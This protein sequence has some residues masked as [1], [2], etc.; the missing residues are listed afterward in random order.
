[1]TTATA[2]LRGRTV[3]LI[4]L[5]SISTLVTAAFIAV[6]AFY[7]A[8][9]WLD[10]SQAWLHPEQFATSAYVWNFPS[11]EGFGERIRKA[12]DWKAFDPNVNRVRPLND[13]ADTIDAIARPYLTQ[14]FEPH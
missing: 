11:Q 8:T 10:Y 7:A 4:W 12:L 3:A 5:S 6:T 9:V 14:L 1:M 2:P 13:L